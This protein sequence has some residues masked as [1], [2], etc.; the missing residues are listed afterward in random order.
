[1]TTASALQAI[2]HFDGTSGSIRRLSSSAHR[3]VDYRIATIFT[4]DS[5]GTVPILNRSTV[6]SRRGH[7]AGRSERMTARGLPSKYSWR[8]DPH[9]RNILRHIPT[10]QL[11]A[12]RVRPQT[13]RK[14]R[15]RPATG[16]L[17][18]KNTFHI[19]RATF[20]KRLVHTVAGHRY[21]L[22]RRKPVAVIRR[23][24]PR[25]PIAASRPLCAAAS[26][27]KRRECV[28]PVRK[29]L[30]SWIA[31]S[32]RAATNRGPAIV[33]RRSRFKL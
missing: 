7:R 25:R 16:R 26:L 32:R 3:S 29:T 10:P 4:C 14:K 17:R 1:M 13:R 8:R 11:S 21:I 30:G 6:A 23:W 18:E 31:I 2:S 22:L 19:S 24:T 15:S 5:S 12:L 9:Q 33:A 28:R 27:Q 20:F